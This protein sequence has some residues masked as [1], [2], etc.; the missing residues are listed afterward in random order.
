VLLGDTIIEAQTPLTLQLKNVFETQQAP[1]VA[2]QKVPMEIAHRYG[3]FVGNEISPNVFKAKELVEKPPQ[4]SIPSNLVFAGR[5]ILTPDIFDALR[6]TKAG[7]NN[8]IQLTDAI[9]ILMQKSDVFGLA[10]EGTRHDVGNTLDFIKTNLLLGLQREDVG[11]ELK[12]W[13][14][15]QLSSL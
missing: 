2:L 3:V 1:V 8:E 11:E 9:K 14:Q 4:G 6:N 10:F 13:L 15:K 12:A 5:Y 7:V